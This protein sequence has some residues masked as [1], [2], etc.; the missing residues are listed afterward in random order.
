VSCSVHCES[1]M[2]HQEC[3]RAAFA[4]HAGQCM[5]DLTTLGD[6]DAVGALRGAA[7]T[8][9]SDTSPAPVQV[10]AWE[11]AATALFSGANALGGFQHPAQRECYVLLQVAQPSQTLPP[12]R[13]TD[14]RCLSRLTP[15]VTSC[16]GDIFPGHV[17][18]VCSLPSRSPFS[19]GAGR[20]LAHRRGLHA[21]AASGGHGVHHGRAGGG[22]AAAAARGGACSQGWLGAAQFAGCCR[23]TAAAGCCCAHHA[24][25][26][27]CVCPTRIQPCTSCE[28]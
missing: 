18:A 7:E 27:R 26:E 10:G 22:A 11:A 23:R 2:P 3:V 20:L 16:S 25:A 14:S 17:T 1:H 12:N 21:G 15:L 8:F 4:Q 9:A 24:S 28:S 6:V 13:G 19:D 5:D